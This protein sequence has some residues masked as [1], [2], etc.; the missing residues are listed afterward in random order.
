MMEINTAQAKDLI[1]DCIRAQLV[2]ML[3]GSPGTGKSALIHAIAEEFNLKVID[4]R[5]GQCDPTDLNGFP[6]IDKESQKAKYMPMDTFPLE[7]DALPMKS[8]ATADKPATF[9]EG[10][11]LFLDEMN[12]APLAVQA[13]AYKLVLDHA[14]GQFKMHPKV[15][16]VAAG[17]KD[18]DNAIVNRMGTA[19]QS[20]MIHLSL[21]TDHKVWMDW[22]VGA[23]IDHR[24]TSFINFTPKNLHK[25]DPDHSDV[26]FACNRTWEFA[27]RLISPY[28]GQIPNDKRPLLA[29]TIS[30]GMAAEFMGFCKI[31]KTLPT[32]ADILKNPEGI[33]MPEEPSQMYA[34]SGSIANHCE[35]GQIEP[36]MKFV[37]RMN[38]EFQVITL[39]ELMKRK[40]EM[41]KA[42]PVME[43]ISRNAKELF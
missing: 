34:L 43:W 2:P 19:M 3:T 27:S 8:E 36:L 16:I 24:I 26:T 38:L 12:S 41:V 25:F 10:W 7:T 20:R 39:Q 28:P 22:A 21:A 31:Y 15:A 30:E 17:N 32:V 9:Y 35:A 37:N 6:T 4:M 5:L 40:R 42:P 29:G 23:G 33:K 18:T 1:V 14:V 11:L 13:A